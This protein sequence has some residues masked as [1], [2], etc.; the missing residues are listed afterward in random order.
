MQRD[1]FLTEALG[2]CWHE[3]K[4]DFKRVNGRDIQKDCK[5]GAS[6]GWERMGGHGRPNPVFR[7]RQTDFSTWV[8]FGKLWG[9][10]QEQSWFREFLGWFAGVDHKQ[11]LCLTKVQVVSLCNPDQFANAVHQYLVDNQ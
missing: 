5:C 10:S 9:W 2:E 1:K 11:G 7:F 4:P 6:S 8:G 3:P